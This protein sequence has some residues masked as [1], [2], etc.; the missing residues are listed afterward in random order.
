LS[1][2]D[3]YSVPPNCQFE[4]DD[5]EDPWTFNQKFDYIHGRALLSCF[6]HPPSV[7]AQAF[8]ALAPGGYIEFQDGAFPLRSD[9]GTLEGTRLKEWNELIIQGA[10]ALGRP[11]TNT[12]NYKRWFEEA[13]FVDVE[14]RVYKVAMS[15]WPKEKSQKILA[16]WSQQN[17]LDGIDGMSMAIFTRALGW[18]AEQVQLFLVGVREDIKS[19]KIHAYMAS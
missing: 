18:T 14:E 11:W 3:T 2:S 10:N 16:L 8:D 5:A 7:I 6:R 12:P 13:G 19:R 15:P 9:D 1:L 4:V 17:I